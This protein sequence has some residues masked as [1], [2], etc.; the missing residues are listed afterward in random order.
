MATARH[1]L[2]SQ[3]K[4]PAAGLAVFEEVLTRI[5]R[6]GTAGL[7]QPLALFNEFKAAGNRKAQF[8]WYC[9]RFGSKFPQAMGDALVEA[10]P[11]QYDEDEDD[12]LIDEDDKGTVAVP[13]QTEQ[14]KALRKVI[15]E[16]EAVL[17][18]LGNEN[19]SRRVTKKARTVIEAP[20]VAAQARAT[21]PGAAVENLWRTWAVEKY[22]IPTKKGATFAYTSSRANGQVTTHRVTKVTDEG[23]YAVRV[24]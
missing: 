23:V 16:A 18:S 11:A 9:N 19:H 10:D 13:K 20:A 22:G 12:D 21:K 8:K 15:A 24:S 3:A 5:T 2:V 4:G 7:P 6:N 1:I 17:A 14:E